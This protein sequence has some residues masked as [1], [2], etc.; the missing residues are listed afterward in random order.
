M[1]DF[2]NSLLT[3]HLRVTTS[4]CLSVI[5][6]AANFPALIFSFLVFSD[7]AQSQRGISLV[8]EFSA[9]NTVYHGSLTFVCLEVCLHKQLFFI[10]I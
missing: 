8:L 6:H 4:I 3:E 9:A 2:Q 10:G 7:L 1:Q 5:S